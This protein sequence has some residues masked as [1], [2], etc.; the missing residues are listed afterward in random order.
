[1]FRPDD[2]LFLLSLSVIVLFFLFFRCRSSPEI[3]KNV[4]GTPGQCPPSMDTTGAYSLFPRNVN[5]FTVGPALGCGLK[6]SGLGETSLLQDWP[7]IRLMLIYPEMASKP[8]K[9]STNFHWVLWLL[10]LSWWV[11]SGQEKPTKSILQ[12]K[13]KFSHFDCCPLIFL[14]H[15]CSPRSIKAFVV[16]K[17]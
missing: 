5:N 10:I 9:L 4:Q 7:P 16:R 14:L 11:T 8:T 3:S 17:P 15:E 12:F 6:K 13:L 1:M 2:C